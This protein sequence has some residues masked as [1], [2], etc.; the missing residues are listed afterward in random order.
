MSFIAFMGIRVRD[1][2]NKRCQKVD[3]SSNRVDIREITFRFLEIG[4]GWDMV[5]M[6][7]WVV[8]DRE[9]VIR[10]AVTKMTKNT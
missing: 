7:S 8:V 9:V 5:E 3:S 10:K 2:S 4:P 6:S 1:A